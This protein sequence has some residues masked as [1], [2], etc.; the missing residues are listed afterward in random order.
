M[1]TK[2]P[3]TTQQK[4]RNARRQ[5]AYWMSQRQTNPVMG[6]TDH[7]DFADKEAMRLAGVIEKWEKLRREEM[8]RIE[9]A[10]AYENTI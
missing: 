5:F 3:M 9:S 10:R 4:L 6:R 8:Q 1:K 7:Q 2:P